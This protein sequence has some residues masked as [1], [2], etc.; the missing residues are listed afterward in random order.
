[1]KRMEWLPKAGLSVMAICQS[2]SWMVSC[3]ASAAQHKKKILDRKS[4]DIIMFLLNNAW[5]LKDEVTCLSLLEVKELQ[6]FAYQLLQDTTSR[7]LQL[8]CETHS[9]PNSD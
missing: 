6:F 7:A 4:L 5:I 3:H 9:I 1:M 2:V 8:L